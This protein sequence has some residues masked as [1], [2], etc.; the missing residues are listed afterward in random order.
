M[1]RVSLSLRFP[2]RPVPSPSCVCCLAMQ[3]AWQ[4]HTR[5]NE[6]AFQP[7]LISDI[8]DPL[9]AQQEKPR[10]GIRYLN[11]NQKWNIMLYFRGIVS[12]SNLWLVSST[13]CASGHPWKV[14]LL[15]HVNHMIRYKASDHNKSLFTSVV[16][17]T[18][19]FHTG[20][21]QYF[22]IGEMLWWLYVRCLCT[23]LT[24]FII[25]R[26]KCYNSMN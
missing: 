8:Y 2:S 22:R 23:G 1:G 3:M 5:S 17:H 24:C 26:V 4:S 18:L 16:Q 19:L 10:Q 20:K 6:I 25:V 15:G 12:P 21:E 14:C 9:V 7:P 13:F 11:K